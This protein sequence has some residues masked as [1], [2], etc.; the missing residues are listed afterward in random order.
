VDRLSKS[1]YLAYS[2]LY[3]THFD[4]RKTP[5]SSTQSGLV[6]GMQIRAV[7]V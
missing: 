4:W 7:D 5:E 6:Y 3:A 2:G 1:Q